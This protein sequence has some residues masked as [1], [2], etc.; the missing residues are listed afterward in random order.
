[1][2]TS[3]I[4]NTKVI[5]NKGKM[6]ETCD[7]FPQAQCVGNFLVSMGPEAFL[8]ELVGQDS[9][10]WQAIDDLPYQIVLVNYVLGKEG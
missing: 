8:E 10:L 5:D 1:M 2:L 9:C 6:D 7:V 3:Y 4:F